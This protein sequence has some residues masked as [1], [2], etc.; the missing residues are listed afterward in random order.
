M[1]ISSSGL[2]AVARNTTHGFLRNCSQTKYTDPPSRHASNSLD[3]VYMLSPQWR[4]NGHDVSQLTTL[5][6]VYWAV[7]A[8]IDQY[9]ISSGIISDHYSDVIMGA[10][11]SQISP[12]LRLFTQPFIQTQIQ[13]NIKVPCQWPLCGEFTGDRW[14]TLT[15]GQ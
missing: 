1:S 9:L 3:N 14:I 2:V 4:H 7:C 12:A 11:T 8:G 5:T 15:N 10:M 13:E 6:I